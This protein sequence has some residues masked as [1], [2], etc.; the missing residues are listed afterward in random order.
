M[1][2]GKAL[3]RRGFLQK[4]LVGGALLLVGGAGSLALRST[5]LSSAPRGPLKLLSLQEHAVFTAAAARI[6]P[7]APSWPTPEALDCG[8]KADALLAL[9]HPE[10]GVDFKR[11]LTLF[12]NGL[13]G[14][15][16]HGRPTPFTRLDPAAQEARLDAWR[17]SR[18]AL[19]RSGYL[20]L[21]RLTH[22]S[23]YS[24][25]E[26]YALIGYPGPPDVPAEAR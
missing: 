9:C 7:A 26:V 2:G 12:E 25:P 21:T 4:G 16:T 10:V 19:L 20:A 24:S 3:P 6:I 23:Y 18:M 1:S 8:G 22:A 5:R 14:L 17:R 13:F 11:L 15:V